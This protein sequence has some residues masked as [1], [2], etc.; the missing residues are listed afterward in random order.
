MKRLIL[1][2][3]VLVAVAGLA[4]VALAAP[5][6]DVPV[7]TDTVVGLS[8]YTSIEI[9]TLD[10]NARFMLTN[11]GSDAADTV[12]THYGC[13]GI[14]RSLSWSFAYDEIDTLVIDI[15]TASEVIYTLE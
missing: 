15:T 5:A 11:G 1:T 7:T 14:L 4:V 10:G 6:S 2:A 9:L 8:G 13:D 3:L 12:R